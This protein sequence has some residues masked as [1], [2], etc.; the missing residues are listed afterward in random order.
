M[1]ENGLCGGKL[2]SAEQDE[3]VKCGGQQ[4]DVLS[5][6]F[7]SL[8]RHHHIPADAKGWGR[9]TQSLAC[10]SRRG[11]WNFAPGT[12]LFMLDR[13]YLREI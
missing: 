9:E 3:Q 13:L 2:C 11:R 8:Y 4:G 6:Q 7:H 12:N 5:L 10:L 1:K